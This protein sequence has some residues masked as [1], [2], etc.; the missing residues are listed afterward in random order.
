MLY[1]NLF[2]TIMGAYVFLLAILLFWVYPYVFYGFT[3]VSMHVLLFNA[4]FIF[5]IFPLNGPLFYKI[6]LAAVGNVVGLVWEFFLAYIATSLCQQF[7]SVF[8]ELYFVADPFFELFWIV[9]M[10]SLGLSILAQ[11]AKN[12]RGESC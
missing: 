11:K 3:M 2:H 9:S 1:P 10:W 12:I 8:S 5:L 6:S 4:L 7:G